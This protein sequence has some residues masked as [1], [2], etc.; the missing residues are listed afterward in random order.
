MKLDSSAKEPGAGAPQVIDPVCGMTI[1]PEKSAG[2]WDYAGITYYFCGRGC[3]EKFQT[4]PEKYLHKTAPDPK[5]E[6][7]VNGAVP[8]RQNQPALPP[9][10]QRP[11]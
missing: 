8:R 6:L 5:P 7:M 9:L 1:A 2:K 4:D 11:A 10:W 3:L